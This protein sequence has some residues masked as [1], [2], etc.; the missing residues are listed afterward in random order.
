LATGR[1]ESPINICRKNP[2][3]LV[4]YHQEIQK[5]ID[6]KFV[7]E[8]NMDYEKSSTPISHIIRSSESTTRFLWS[9]EN[10]I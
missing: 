3:D 6:S 2:E 10:K 9:G 5:L 4:N 7:E 8:A 1:V